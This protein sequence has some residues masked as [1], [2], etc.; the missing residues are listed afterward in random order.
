M[1]TNI[2][3]SSSLAHFFL[4]WEI[5]QIKVLEKIKTHIL[6]SV[7]FFFPFEN[8]AVCEKMWINIVERGRLQMIIWRMRIACWMPKATSTHTWVV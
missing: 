5:F 6:V 1:E 7:T 2:H 4:E 8:R 3:C